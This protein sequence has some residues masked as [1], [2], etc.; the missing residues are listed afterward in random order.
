MF[1]LSLLVR[2]LPGVPKQV[3]VMAECKPLPA[4]FVASGGIRTKSAG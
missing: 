3:Q 4:F 1:N 2:I